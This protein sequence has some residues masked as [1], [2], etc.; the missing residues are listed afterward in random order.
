MGRKKLSKGSGMNRKKERARQGVAA[1]QAA[2]YGV[3][4]PQEPSESERFLS[5]NEIGKILNVTGE[6]VKQWIYHRRLPAVKLPNG[7]WKV[8]IADFEQFLKARNEVGKRRVLV[9]DTRAGDLKDVLE[10]VEKLGHQPVVAHNYA[11][12]LLKA[13]DNHPALFIINVS[14]KEV[15]PWKLAEK[16]RS[17][18]SLKNAP[19]LLLADADLSDDDADRAMQL[20]A[21]GFLKRPISSDTLSAEIERILDGSL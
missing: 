10:T 9:T 18:K 14:M 5:P 15:D 17:L 1:E 12:A 13:S 7:Y 8:K 21:Q 6:A 4:L 16:I 2:K 11:D 3:S 19:I 20:G